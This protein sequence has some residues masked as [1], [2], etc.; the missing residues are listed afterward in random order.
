MG[1]VVRNPSPLHAQRVHRI[2]FLH[3]GHWYVLSANSGS[4]SRK[5]VTSRAS[6]D[7]K[8]TLHSLLIWALPR[9]WT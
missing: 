5:Y 9:I 2:M 6:A 4:L 3:Q 1:E 7:P 8:P